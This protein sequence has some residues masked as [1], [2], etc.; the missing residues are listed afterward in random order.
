MFQYLASRSFFRASPLACTKSFMS[1]VLIIFAK[2]ACLFLFGD[3]NKPTMGNTYRDV[4]DFVHAKRLARKRPPLAGKISR[5]RRK[6][7][8]ITK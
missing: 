1:L 5:Q 8:I 2:S 6:Y 3:V 4:N 7:L